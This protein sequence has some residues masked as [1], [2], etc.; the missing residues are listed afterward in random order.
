ME[1]NRQLNFENQKF[2]IGMDVHL[3]NWKVTIRNNHLTLKTYSM[4]TS[5]K[6]LS[7]YMERN[8]PGGKYYSVYEAGFCGFWIH[9]KLEKLGFDN[10]VVHPADVP[11]TDKEKTTKTDKVDSIKLAREL[12]NGTMKSIYIPDELNQQLRSLHRLRNRQVQNSTRVKNRIKSHLYFNGITI[13][14]HDETSHWSGRFIDWLKSLE[15]SNPAANDYLR[16]CIEEL[17]DCRKRIVEIIRLLRTYSNKYGFRT[18]IDNLRTIPGIG[19]ITAI[20]YYTELM[21]VFRFRN[22]DHLS[23][24]VGLIPSVSSSGDRDSNR[25]LT[26]RRNTY[27][28][29]LIVEAAWIAIRKDPALLQSYNQLIKRMTKQDAIIRIARK[30]LNRIRYVWK[31]QRP[32]VYAVVK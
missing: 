23:S 26:Y 18:T 5:P 8:Y 27:L 19:F 22:L 1:Q 32:Y 30:L 15:F 16:L 24:Y 12:E 6:E 17:V 28:R 4:N 31:N 2:F 3:K 13:P 29:H 9:R 11:T 14:S 20:A 10:I 25:G 21:N 7:L